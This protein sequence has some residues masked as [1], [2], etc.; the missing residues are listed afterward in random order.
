MGAGIINTRTTV[1]ITVVNTLDIFFYW[2]I[3][4]I[5]GMTTPYTIPVL[6]KALRL[7]QALAGKNGETT[8]A[9][10]VRELRISPST[11]YRILQTLVAHN[12][13]RQVGSG[14]FAFSTGM[15]PLLRPLSDYQRLFESLEEP[16][17]RVVLETGLTAKISIKQGAQAVTVFRVESARGL[18]PSSKVG[19]A[20]PLAYGSSGA[21]LMSGL[22]D[23]E[24]AEILKKSP[25]EVWR[26]QTADDVTSRVRS[27]RKSGTCYDPGHFQSPVHGVSAP[28]FLEENQVFAALTLVGWEEDFS[29][30]RLQ[31]LQTLARS[32]AA[33]CAGKLKHGGS[34]D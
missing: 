31:K 4:F 5:T 19:A 15:L 32:C 22:E 23:A 14:R 16:L 13:L 30:K 24:I 11:C 29:G 28:V 8:S 25:P 21:C 34:H 7:V 1:A 3:R 12:W 2:F 26:L 17:E 6:D 27:V 33:S 9:E 10:L 18:S 20:F